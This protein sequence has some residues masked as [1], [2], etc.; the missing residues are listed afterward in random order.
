MLEGR[1][2]DERTWTS[3]FVRPLFI[4][5]GLGKGLRPMLAR[6]SDMPPEVRRAIAE[7]LEAMEGGDYVV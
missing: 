5:D 7:E 3:E 1:S 4:D 2:Y 6:E